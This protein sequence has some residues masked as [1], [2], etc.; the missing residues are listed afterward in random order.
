MFQIPLPRDGKPM[1]LHRSFQTMTS[2]LNLQVN[3]AN[4]KELKLNEQ[5]FKMSHK[6]PIEVKL[7]YRNDDMPENQWNMMANAEVEKTF[8]CQL[9]TYMDSIEC[10]LV[11]LFELGTVHHQYYLI[12][13]KLKEQLKF[14]DSILSASNILSTEQPQ[15]IVTLTV[16]IFFTKFI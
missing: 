10:D 1:Q 2:V 3:L 5:D 12:N 7:A 6:I 9:N 16:K 14:T 4:K 15:T 13:L 11:Q 8:S